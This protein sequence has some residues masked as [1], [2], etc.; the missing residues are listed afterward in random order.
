MMNAADPTRLQELRE[1][2]A[3]LDGSILELVASR[4]TIATEIGQIKTAIG[5]STRDFS[6]E[7]RLR[8]GRALPR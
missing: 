1:R 3:E 5:R 4:Q 6:Q 7:E 8:F 2:L